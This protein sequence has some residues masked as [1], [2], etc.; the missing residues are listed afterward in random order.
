MGDRQ[1]RPL[2]PLV[3]AGTQLGLGHFAAPSPGHLPQAT[4]GQRDGSGA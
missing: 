1:L 4:A 2:P 3:C